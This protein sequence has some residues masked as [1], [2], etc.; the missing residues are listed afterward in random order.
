MAKK[1]FC[2]KNFPK[3]TSKNIFQNL[4]LALWGMVVVLEFPLWVYFMLGV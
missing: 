2:F 1:R 4:S 3:T